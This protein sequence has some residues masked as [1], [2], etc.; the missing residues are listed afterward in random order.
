MGGFS[1]LPTRPFQCVDFGLFCFS[2][3]FLGYGVLVLFHCLFFLPSN[4]RV[5][6][7]LST[8]CVA[9][10]VDFQFSCFPGR[11]SDRCGAAGLRGFW[12]AS[13]VFP[14]SVL[15]FGYLASFTV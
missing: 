13:L 10:S 9:G 12:V 14:S 8:F 11:L 15:W 2:K 1:Q 3:V 5:L 4:F 6:K 7:C